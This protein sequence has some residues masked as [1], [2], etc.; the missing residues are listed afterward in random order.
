MAPVFPP[1]VNAGIDRVV[2]QKGRTY[3][4][5]TVKQVRAGAFRLPPNGM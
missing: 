5:G 3:L 2:V 4:T 1:S